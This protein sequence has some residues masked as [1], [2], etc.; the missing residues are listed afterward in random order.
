MGIKNFGEALKFAMKLE[1]ECSIFYGE[2]YK[3]AENKKL[4]N[5]FHEIL[6]QNEKRKKILETIF[7]DNIFSDMD[8]GILAPIDT[9]DETNYRTQINSILSSDIVSICKS[10]KAMESNSEHFYNNLF[11][12]LSF[13]PRSTK[14]RIERLLKQNMERRIKIEYI[15][16]EIG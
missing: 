14:R 11:E 9:M 12:R 8:T 16:I 1:D 13:G 15:L 4:R 7:N 3:C 2:A 6:D 10:L 5:W